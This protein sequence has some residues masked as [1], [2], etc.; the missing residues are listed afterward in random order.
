MGSSGAYYPA[1]ISISTISQEPN[2][3][4]RRTSFNIG[5]PQLTGFSRRGFF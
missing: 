4:H 3:S 1:A 5:S 2:A